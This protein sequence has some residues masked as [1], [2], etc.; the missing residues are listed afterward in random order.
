MKG[1]F[2]VQWRKQPRFLEF[3]A[4][5]L[6]ENRISDPGAAPNGGTA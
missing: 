3:R 4:A 2:F 5:I 1:E 6:E